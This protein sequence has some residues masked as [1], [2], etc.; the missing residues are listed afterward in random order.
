MN[1]Y[2]M[3]SVLKKINKVILALSFL[4]FLLT[5]TFANPP[6]GTQTNISEPTT[7][8][9]LDNLP[10]ELALEIL[11]QLAKEDPLAL[12]KLSQTSKYWNNFIE[13]WPHLT[14]ALKDARAIYALIIRIDQI[15]KSVP[16]P[17]FWQRARRFV[18]NWISPEKKFNEFKQLLKIHDDFLKLFGIHI[19]GF[20]QSRLGNSRTVTY[21][22]S[23]LSNKPISSS[24]EPYL[25]NVIEQFYQIFFKKL[26]KLIDENTTP[27]TENTLENL[28]NIFDHVFQSP[29]LSEPI[30][31]ALNELAGKYTFDRQLIIL[32][33]DPEN[34]TTHTIKYSL[35]NT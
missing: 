24:S 6:A 13:S 34:C 20:L 7:Y 22:C 8:S 33:E 2:I 10:T 4:T 27:L 14:N 12:G 3:S 11:E 30:Q 1:Y 15:G 26:T 5:L 28:L 16:S 17:G 35:S 9:Y 32:E 23:L 29:Y 31:S 19:F 25:K 18:K 21:G